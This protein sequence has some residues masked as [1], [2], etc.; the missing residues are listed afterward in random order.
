M[1]VLVF[2]C[3]FIERKVDP[4]V[5]ASF[6]WRPVTLHKDIFI[7]LG[8]GRVSDLPRIIGCW[9]TPRLES[10]SPAP[11]SAPLA[12]TPH[13]HKGWNA[14]LLCLQKSDAH[15][16]NTEVWGG[17]GTSPSRRDS[18]HSSGSWKVRCVTFA[19]RWPHWMDSWIWPA[20][21]LAGTRT[22]TVCL[23][24]RA[25]AR[26]N[27]LHHPTYQGASRAH[28]EMLSHPLITRLCRVVRRRPNRG[29]TKRPHARQ[30]LLWSITGSV[31]LSWTTL[32]ANGKVLQR[33]LFKIK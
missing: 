26:P 5:L 7:L 20:G 16:R 13:A 12:V 31:S 2:C 28:K 21:H 25:H 30:S 11:K 22:P 6:R 19:E 17:L 29:Q 33:W 32:T 23:I 3:S 24:L 9:A 18:A 1:P 27:P 4:K 8:T 15:R 14:H 10:G